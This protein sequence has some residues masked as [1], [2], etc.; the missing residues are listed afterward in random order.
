MR[1]RVASGTTAGLIAAALAGACGDGD[2]ESGTARSAGAPAT[3]AKPASRAA[4]PVVRA[5]SLSPARRR[6]EAA[7]V[8]ALI[9]GITDRG[10][11]DDPSVCN[12]VFTLRYLKQATGEDAAG[13]VAAC[14]RQVVGPGGRAKL[15]RIERIELRRRRDGTIAG[16]VQYLAE[17]DGTRARAILLLIRRPGRAYRVDG[18]VPAPQPR[19]TP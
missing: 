15:E 6:A 9:L 7:R 14:R 17:V 12:R 10:D 5:P 1:L 13:A 8:R 19:R 3:T 4:P 2:R 11:P 16:R 18:G